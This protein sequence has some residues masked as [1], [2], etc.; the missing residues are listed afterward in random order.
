LLSNGL[1]MVRN[2]LIIFVKNPVLGKVKSRLAQSI[3]EGKALSVYKKLLA[4][5]RETVG[6]LTLT[7]LVSY[8]D[9]IDQNDIWEN[10]LFIKSK[11]K[12]SDLGER[13]YNALID[14]QNLSFDKICIIGSDIFELTPGIIENA[15]NLLNKYEVVLGPARDGGYYLIGMKSPVKDLFENKHWGSD[16]VLAETIEN[17]TRLGLTYKLLSTLN[18]IDSLEDI[19]VKDRNYLL[20]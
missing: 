12:G 11:Q 8:S 17:I 15:F 4:N 19:N 16:S 7:K 9:R 10:E 14:G 20:S 2:L 3:G 5:T 6:K 1:S 18:D 13:M